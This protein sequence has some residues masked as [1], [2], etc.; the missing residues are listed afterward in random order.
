MMADD[1]QRLF[2]TASPRTSPFA[3]ELA[4]GSNRGRIEE[5][6]VPHL[7]AIRKM[8]TLRAGHR[9]RPY[10]D[11][12]ERCWSKKKKRHC[13]RVAPTDW[14]LIV[15]PVRRYRGWP[16]LSTMCRLFSAGETPAPRGSLPGPG[17]IPDSSPPDCLTAD[18]CLPHMALIWS[19]PADGCI[20]YRCETWILST[21]PKSRLRMKAANRRGELR[22]G[23]RSSFEYSD[24]VL[25]SCFAPLCFRHPAWRSQSGRYS[26]FEFSRPKV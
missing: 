19:R 20:E 1:S 15:I 21:F 13:R 5:G 24:L 7:S 11:T 18:C 14:P 23:I 25:V 9:P 3:K 26:C 22:E 10:R 17:D 2:S 4:P 8:A 12:R 6:F 16:S